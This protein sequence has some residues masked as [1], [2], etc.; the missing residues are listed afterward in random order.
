MLSYKDLAYV[1]PFHEAI[2]E[3]SLEKISALIAMHDMASLLNGTIYYGHPLV[4][5]INAGWSEGVL[6]LCEALSKELI[7]EEKNE[8]SLLDKLDNLNVSMLTKEDEERGPGAS[9]R[10]S[11]I[12]GDRLR[13][14]LFERA[15]KN[16]SVLEV[17]NC[18]SKEGDT[19]G[20]K[21]EEMR[22]QNR[23]EEE[24]FRQDA[25]EKIHSLVESVLNEQ[26]P[27]C[28]ALFH[29]LKETKE[30]FSAQ[31]IDHINS[32]L[33]YAKNIEVFFTTLARK[34]N[35]SVEELANK[36]LLVAQA[37]K[38][39]KSYR[40]N[41]LK[42]DNQPKEWSN[43]AKYSPKV[44]RYNELIFRLK[45]AIKAKPFSNFPMKFNFIEQGEVCFD[46]IIEH[47]NDR[48]IK[49]KTVSIIPEENKE[50]QKNNNNTWASLIDKSFSSHFQ[51]GS[52]KQPKKEPRH[53]TPIIAASPARIRKP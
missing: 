44:R 28:D 34:M 15:K 7:G 10:K 5:A 39:D 48:Y 50:E 23:A 45:F 22:Q 53:N 19:Y 51:H 33:R 8:K 29:E 21:L 40:M 35:S 4:M 49:I 3:R 52:K 18:F 47:I 42:K 25:R 16:P 36:F 37:A 43:A 46:A 41:M 17:L 13:H 6:A 32:T 30:I 12:S 2:K 31:E 38:N 1:N 9:P 20:K 27:I 24:K 11:I 14:E 26:E